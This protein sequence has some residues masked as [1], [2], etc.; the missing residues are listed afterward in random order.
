MFYRNTSPLE[1]KIQFSEK[2]KLNSPSQGAASFLPFHCLFSVTF[3]FTFIVN[4]FLPL[5]AFT[6]LVS[7]HF[8]SVEQF[9]ISDLTPL[10][11]IFSFFW[12]L[13]CVWDTKVCVRHLVWSWQWGVHCPVSIRSAQH[14]GHTTTYYKVQSV[15]LLESP[16]SRLMEAENNKQVTVLSWG[17]ATI[18]QAHAV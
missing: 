1:K 17:I 15:S 14:S 6:G 3:T 12:L 2:C 16:L 7:R 10:D 5:A 9:V 8:S 13:T 4:L 11:F 18:N